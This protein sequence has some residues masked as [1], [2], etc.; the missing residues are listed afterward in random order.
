[1][2]TLIKYENQSHKH[3]EQGGGNESRGEWGM[4]SL[5]CKVEIRRK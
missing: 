3:A 5:K 4:G 1:M 2:P